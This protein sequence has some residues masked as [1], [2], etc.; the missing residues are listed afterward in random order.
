MVDAPL[1]LEG[2]KYQR[3]KFLRATKNRFCPNDDI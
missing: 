3:Y 2:D 1:Y